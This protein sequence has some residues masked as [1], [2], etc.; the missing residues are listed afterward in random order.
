MLCYVRYVVIGDGLEEE[1]CAEHMG[2]P[3]VR[4][5]LTPPPA[6]QHQEA[7]SQNPAATTGVLPQQAPGSS[8]ASAVGGA[9]N[10]RLK[11]TATGGSADGGSGQENDDVDDDD[12]D[13]DDDDD[14]EENCDN[15]VEHKVDRAVDAHSSQQQQQP[16]LGKDTNAAC[17]VHGSSSAVVA[18]VGEPEQAEA[19][20]TRG[21]KP[22]KP[23]SLSS[24]SQQEQPEQQQP[25]GKQLPE[26]CVGPARPKPRIQVDALGSAGHTL[27][28]LTAQQ[29]LQLALSIK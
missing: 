29:L 16:V 11:V 9:A 19:G 14:D 21:P 25:A 28:D 8:G 1:V 17:V 7:K 2:W 15:V 4:V 26:V 6:L 18:Q 20:A 13:D 22:S 24:R 12:G 23:M 27:L 10:K 3:F 5:T